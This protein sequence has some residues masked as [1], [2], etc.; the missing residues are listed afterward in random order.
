MNNNNSDST[1]TNKEENNKEQTN[2]PATPEMQD[3][4]GNDLKEEHTE[5]PTESGQ[6]NTEEDSSIS[7]TIGTP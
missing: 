5:K 2:I 7:E 4:A 6:I 1:N 3:R